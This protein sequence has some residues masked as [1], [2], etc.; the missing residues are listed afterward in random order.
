MAVAIL[1]VLLGA[2]AAPVTVN[3]TGNVVAAACTVDNNGIYSVIMSDVNAA[4]LSPANSSGIW[5]N[6]DVTLSNC[7]EGTSTVTANFDGTADGTDANKYANA[8]GVGYATNVSVQLQNRSGT[9]ADKGKNSTMTVNVDASKNATF[10]LQTRPYSTMG[11]VTVGD[12]STV[13]SINFTY[14]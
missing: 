4:T 8:I 7:P 3:I 11:G 6:F 1:F 14:N 2:T 9:V 5:K 10:D 13:V 12:I